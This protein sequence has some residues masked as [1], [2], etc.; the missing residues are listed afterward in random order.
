VTERVI[1]VGGGLVGLHCAYFL[2]RAGAEV[3]VLER[4]RVGSGASRGN[5]G[6]ICP[7]EVEPLPA[8]GLVRD[9]IGNLF[10]RD[11]AFFVEPRTAPFVAGFLLRMARHCTGSAHERGLSAMAQLGRRTLELYDDL[12]REGIAVGMGADGYLKCSSSLE[13]AQ[14]VRDEMARMADRGLAQEPGPLLGPDELAEVEPAL[15]EHARAGFVQPGE[16]W[17]DPAALVDR[18]A[19]ALRAMGAE[20]VEG[21]R[22]SHMRDAGGRVTVES[23]LGRFDGEAVVVAAGAWSK[24]LCRTLGAHL[25]MQPGKGYSFSVRPRS[26][27]RRVL[28]FP[29][30]HVIATPMGERLRFAGTM[31]FDGTYD[32]FDRRRIE[33]IVRAVSPY[34]R[35]IDWADRSE[36]WVGPRPMTPDGLPYIGRLPNGSRIFVAAGHNMLGVT[37]APPTGEAIAG[38][39][40]SGDPGIDLTWFSPQRFARPWRR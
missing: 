6:E 35:G 11:S 22:A 3:I 28:N 26:V 34:L 12:A 27:P 10:R 4:H 2:R 24:E 14:A 39:V 15:S 13:A 30:A 37:L 17:I 32:R 19:D 7:G 23:S 38:L 20:I 1:V 33:A 29:D 21:A 18:L 9:A 16:R 8:P 31:E 25:S 5:A 40:L 36:E